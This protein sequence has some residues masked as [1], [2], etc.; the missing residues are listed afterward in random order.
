[1]LCSHDEWLSLLWWH[2]VAGGDG[3]SQYHF[4]S[5]P[6]ASSHPVTRRSP[7]A[8][9]LCR[10]LID[11]LNC[12]VHKRWC[13]STCR[14][15]ITNGGLSVETDASLVSGFFSR[16]CFLYWQNH[17]SCKGWG[18]ILGNPEHFKGL[19]GYNIYIIL[20]VQNIKKWVKN[21]YVLTITR[22]KISNLLQLWFCLTEIFSMWSW[23]GG[24]VFVWCIHDLEHRP[25]W[26][27]I[28]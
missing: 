23:G 3:A 28:I 27:T 25:A 4:S 18:V 8:L 12:L 7:C 15:C 21:I 22:K 14:W 20:P 19:D 24:I 10:L 1:M 6:L 26:Y 13:R 2:L 5:E 16:S 17:N 9:C 11:D